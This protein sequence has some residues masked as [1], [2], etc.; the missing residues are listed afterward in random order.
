MSQIIAFVVAHEAVLA[1]LLVAVLDLVFALSPS[2]EAN[3]ILHAL[4]LWVGG[5]ANKQPPAPPAVPP[6]AS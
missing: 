1:G 6:A 4:F 5:L 3:G 2:L